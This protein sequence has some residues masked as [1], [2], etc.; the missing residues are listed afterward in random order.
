MW[1]WWRQQRQRDEDIARGADADLFA[2]NRRRWKL[3]GRFVVAACL[4]MASLAVFGLSGRLH[5]IFVTV[6]ALCFVSAFFLVQWAKAER[7]FLNKP[8]P[9]EPPRIFK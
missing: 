6:I 1:D 2:D 7:G 5:K 3:A 4:L 9:K 8:D